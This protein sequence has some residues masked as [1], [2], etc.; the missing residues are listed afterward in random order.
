MARIENKKETKFM[1]DKNDRVFIYTVSES[2][3]ERDQ[4]SV[5]DNHKHPA[6]AEL[7]SV[8]RLRRDA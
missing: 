3:R 4:L 5:K 1:L 6:L 2:Y 8:F 7:L